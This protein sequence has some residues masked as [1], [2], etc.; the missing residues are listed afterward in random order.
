MPLPSR[1][2]G[3]P[4]RPP[5]RPLLPCATQVLGSL[6]QLQARL[7]SISSSPLEGAARVQVTVAEVKYQTLGKGRVGVCSTYLS[8]RLQ[9]GAAGEE[10]R[11]PGGWRAALRA[12]DWGDRGMA[13]PQAGRHGC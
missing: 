1:P 12:G 5:A 11:V 7:Y 4:R 8:E 9:V 10:L 2:G 3:R 13:A 6:R